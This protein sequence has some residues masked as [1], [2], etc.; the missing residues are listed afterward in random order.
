MAEFASGTTGTGTLSPVESGGAYAIE[1]GLGGKNYDM[2]FD[3][4][5][6]DLWVFKSGAK[7]VSAKGVPK[8]AS[9]CGFGP[10]F[11]G[12]FEDGS[13]PNENFVRRLQRSSCELC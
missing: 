9:F 7:C 2:I 5:S 4:G 8:P 13:I 1:V 3:T 11:S 12:T 6:S 10:E